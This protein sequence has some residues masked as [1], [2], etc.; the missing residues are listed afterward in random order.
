M[1][2]KRFAQSA[3]PGILQ[4]TFFDALE[5]LWRSCKSAFC[6][7]G[8]HFWSILGSLMYPW[9]HFW[10]T[11]GILFVSKNRLGRQRCPNEQK[12]QNKVTLLECILVSFFN[13]FRFFRVASRELSKRPRK[14]CLLGPGQT[15]KTKPSLKREHD[16]QVLTKFR[17]SWIWGCF[18]ELI[19]ELL[20]LS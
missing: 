7:L 12:P 18:W 19:L 16:L 2:W 10:S 1:Y 14:K 5:P 17:K 4:L 15:S 8:G 6:D 11:V 13:N 20:V 9:G 3:G